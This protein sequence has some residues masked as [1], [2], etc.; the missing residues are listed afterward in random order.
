MVYQKVSLQEKKSRECFL[1]VAQPF[2]NFQI[3]YSFERNDIVVPVRGGG[4]MAHSILSSI[5][6]ASP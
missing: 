4:S 5:T 6:A 3:V 2:I 1:N